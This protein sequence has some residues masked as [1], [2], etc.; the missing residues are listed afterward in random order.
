MAR[1]PESKNFQTSLHLKNRLPRSTPER[2]DLPGLPRSRPQDVR[3]L[4]KKVKQINGLDRGLVFEGSACWHFDWSEH[5]AQGILSEAH[6]QAKPGV[7]WTRGGQS[8]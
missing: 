5:G 4:L 2:I 1:A 3:Q 8:S 7:N 6:F